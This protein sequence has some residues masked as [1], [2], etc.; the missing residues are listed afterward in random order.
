[1]APAP[2]ESKVKQVIAEVYAR[3]PEGREVDWREIGTDDLL[4]SVEEGERSL[5]LDSLDAV[6]IATILE[7]EFDLVL[8]AEIDPLDLRTVRDVMALLE[9]LYAEQRGPDG[10]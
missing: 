5:G 1:M 10:E 4:Y 2:D 8:P 7:E 6:E 3:S 9:R